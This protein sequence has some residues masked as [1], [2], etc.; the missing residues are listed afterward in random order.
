MKAMQFLI[1]QVTIELYRM[2]N[3][4]RSGIDFASHLGGML[5]AV[6]YYN[7]NYY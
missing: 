4:T 3:V 5:F 7:Y 1:I 6:S 2:A